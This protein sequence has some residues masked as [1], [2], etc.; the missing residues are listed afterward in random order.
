MYYRR[1]KS[2]LGELKMTEEIK[3]EPIEKPETIE[4]VGEETYSDNELRA[5]ELGWKPKDKFE[6]SEDDWRS[7]KD[8]LE[9]GEMIGKIRSQ[10]KQLASVEQALKYISTQNVKMYSKG[11]DNAMTELKHQKRQALADG[12][13]VAADVIAEKI[14]DLKVEGRAA[15][16]AAAAPARSITSED[17]E[18][19]EWLSRNQWY[20]NPV[21]RE[22]ADALAVGLIND[23][24]G[25]ISAQQVRD[26]VSKTVREE[27]SHRFKQPATSAPNPDGE[28]RG[29]RNSSG[30][31]RLSKIKSSMSDDEARIMKTMI[32]SAG[33]TEAEY[34]K[35]YSEAR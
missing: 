30:E 32:K 23:Q 34:L 13:H 24:K 5:M 33:M 22:F 19:A 20:N 4:P 3:D 16:N 6:G 1:R 21:M 35:M 31:S 2:A 18:H 7:A 12:D 29:T 26:F 28:G 14:E 10:S 11:Y 9:R 15:V 25:Q 27:F 8:F 17:P